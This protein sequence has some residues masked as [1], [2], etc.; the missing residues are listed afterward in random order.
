MGALI[1]C[2]SGVLV[3]LRASN[4]SLQLIVVSLQL[5]QLL[6][7][8]SLHLHNMILELLESISICHG[9]WWRVGAFK[10]GLASKVKPSANH[11]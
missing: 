2:V 10:R 4:M 6:L 7:M 11:G 1:Q 8:A 3:T 5:A 9:C